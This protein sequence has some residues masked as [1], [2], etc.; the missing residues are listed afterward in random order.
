MHAGRR[1]SCVRENHGLVIPYQ[2]AAPL[3]LSRLKQC[4]QSQ[5]GH[6]LKL[7]ERSVWR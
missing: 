7:L 6:A 1:L 5:S 3:P 4:I 2:R